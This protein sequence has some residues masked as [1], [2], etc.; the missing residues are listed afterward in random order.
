MPTLNLAEGL[1]KRARERGSE[2][3]TDIV[4]D[5]EVKKELQ[6]GTKKNYCRALA[7]WNQWVL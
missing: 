7:L 1:F 4:N 2:I 5:D 3:K 6:P